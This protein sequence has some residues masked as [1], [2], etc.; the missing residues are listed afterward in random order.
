MYKSKNL[1]YGAMISAIIGCFLILFKGPLTTSDSILLIFI[2][3]V[4]ALYT[5]NYHFKDGI[6]IICVNY[7]LAVILLN[8]ISATFLILP[9]LIIG[10]IL[11]I[12]FKNNQNF[13]KI[14]IILFWISL[15]LDIIVTFGFGNLLGIDFL[16]ELDQIALNLSIIFNLNFDKIQKNLYNA[17]PSVL[18]LYS[19]L[20]IILIISLFK[21]LANR[22]NI[23]DF[24]RQ[25]TTISFNFWISLSYLLLLVL[26]LFLNNFSTFI[27]HFL[28]SITI[29]TLSFLSLYI[30]LQ[31]NIIISNYFNNKLLRGIISLL[32]IIL[33]PLAIIIGNILNIIKHKKY[34]YIII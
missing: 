22:L 30:L 2:S 12:L 31:V 19:F 23:F 24:K 25:I 16:S 18:C 5:L 10:F 11:G 21:I 9:H 3:P 26:V 15:L 7:I 14:T 13:K 4:I 33:L 6:V 8:I 29:M 27:S 17:I 34:Y 32:V 28:S 20:K 1:T